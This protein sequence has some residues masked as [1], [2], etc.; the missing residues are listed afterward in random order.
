MWAQIFQSI[1]S[2]VVG[3]FEHFSNSEMSFN[4]SQAQVATANKWNI[5]FVGATILV[6]MILIS[7]VLI[8]DK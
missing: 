5:L 6:I 3:S 8:K 4:E 2:G 1:S 7:V